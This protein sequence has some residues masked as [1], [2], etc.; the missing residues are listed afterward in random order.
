M[1]LMDTLSLPA[2]DVA[3]P[4]SE[5]EAERKTKFGQEA[6]DLAK[7]DGSIDAGYWWSKPDT[8]SPTSQVIR[9]S[10]ST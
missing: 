4:H 10:K 3:A 7:A 5:T 1:P 6:E 2:G 8:W 9:P